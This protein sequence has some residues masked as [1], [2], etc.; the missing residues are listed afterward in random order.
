MDVF[1]IVPNP[2]TDVSQFPSSCEMYRFAFLLLYG[3]TKFR[4]EDRNSICKLVNILASSGNWIQPPPSA[5]VGCC[6]EVVASFCS[7]LLRT[8]KRS[9]GQGKASIRA[10]TDEVEFV[11]V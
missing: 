9:V 2:I 4:E 6:L 3:L 1:T 7:I 11:L 8:S 5:P 10:A